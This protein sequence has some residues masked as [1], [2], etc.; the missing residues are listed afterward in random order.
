MPGALTGLRVP[1]F[2]TLPPGP[3]SPLFLAEAGAEVIKIERP[4]DRDEMRGHE[5][6]W[7]EDSANF[8]VFNRG[9]KSIVL[10]L[11][12]DKG[13]AKLMPLIASADIIVEQSRPGVM[14]RLGLSYD[15]VRAIRPD[16]I[17]SPI[18]GYGRACPRALRAGHDL[19]F[20]GDV[21]LLSL[22]H[23]TPEAPV[24]PAAPI[25]RGAYTIMQKH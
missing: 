16:I 4:N 1:D 13:R 23:G 25:A 5:P 18:T 9:N 2:S 11:K 14:A 10:D 12:T 6:R 3:I 7:S 8:N 22:S 20:H 15:D 24:V 21:G 17:Y 19:N